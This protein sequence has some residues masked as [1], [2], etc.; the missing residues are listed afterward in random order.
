MNVFQWFDTLHPIIQIIVALVA[1][2][3]MAQFW[4]I[5]IYFAFYPLCKDKDIADLFLLRRKARRLDR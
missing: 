2:Y 1:M 5:C 3:G 4:T